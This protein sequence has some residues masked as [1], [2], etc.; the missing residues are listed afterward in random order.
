M[1][2]TSAPAGAQVRSRAKAWSRRV[3][4]VSLALWGL[5]HVVG[6]ASL[7]LLD[8][9]E[10]LDTLA[11]SAPVPAPSTPGDGAAALVH[12]HGFDIAA[13]GL[14]VLALAVWWSTSGRRWQLGCAVAIAAVLDVGLLAYL[15]LPGLLPAG[16]GL[17]GPGLLVLALVALGL[18][19]L[20]A[21]A[22]RTLTTDPAPPSGRTE[23]EV[24]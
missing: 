4:T 8:G 19:A 1:T 6:G 18:E 24:S 14:A 10:G 13:A 23:H 21:P 15:V 3:A 12:F 2:A 22:H 9:R 20:A 11:P 7:L 17:L 5:V 16:E